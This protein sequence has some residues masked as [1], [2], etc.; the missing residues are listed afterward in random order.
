MSLKVS[1]VND[2]LKSVRDYAYGVLYSQVIS[3][4]RNI[5][6]DQAS[7]T[8]LLDIRP[9]MEMFEKHPVLQYIPHTIY[10]IS[11]EINLPPHEYYDDPPADFIRGC[12]EYTLYISKDMTGFST[13][14]IP[15]VTVQKWLLNNNII[16]VHNTQSQQITFKDFYAIDFLSLLYDSSIEENRN[17]KLFKNYESLVSEDKE[18]PVLNV[19]RVDPKAIIPSKK[20]ATDVGF[21]LTIISKVKD[22]GASTALYDT[23]IIVQ[24]PQGYYLEIVPRSSLSKSGYIQS[25]SVGI[26]DPTYTDTL[27][28]PLTRVDPSIPEL[29]LPFTGSQLII[30]KQLHGIMKEVDQSSLKQTARGTGGFGS[31]GSLNQHR[32]M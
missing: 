32:I 8:I 20:R 24:P 19:I 16:F 12:L 29:S 30:R 28:V 10:N 14:Y 18:I 17:A 25:N 23:G 1:I 2:S 9:W 3:L 4:Y 26:I 15:L 11:V 7:K 22:M 21:D 6:N 31:T 27:K 13:Q 5:V